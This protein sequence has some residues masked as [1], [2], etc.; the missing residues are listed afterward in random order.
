M[1]YKIILLVIVIIAIFAFI[2]IIC[3]NK[4]DFA[5]IKIDEAESNIDIYLDKKLDLLKRASAIVKKALKIKTFLDDLEEVSDLN[6]FEFNDLLDDDY[7]ELLIKIDENDKLSKSKKLKEILDD[8]EDNEE[9]R[10]GT[11]KFYNDVVVVF[12]SLVKSF[13]S[14]IYGFFRG[15]KKKEFYNDEKKEIYEILNKEEEKE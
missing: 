4:F 7:N 9:D 11:I 1:L 6:H 8:L 3:K 2:C 13:P 12:N 15:Y 5:I 14:N 10:I